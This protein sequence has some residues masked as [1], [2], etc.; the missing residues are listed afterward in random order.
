MAWMGNV[1]G[2]G[3]GCMPCQAG[4]ERCRVCV[5]EVNHYE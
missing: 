4:D 3:A 1:S 2:T 5:C